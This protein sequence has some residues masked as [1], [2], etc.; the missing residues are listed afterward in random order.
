MAVSDR[1]VVALQRVKLQVFRY[2]DK[3]GSLD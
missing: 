1:L 2:A 3:M